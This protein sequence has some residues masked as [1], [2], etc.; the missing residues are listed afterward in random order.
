[1][2]SASFIYFTFFTFTNIFSNLYLHKAVEIYRNTKKL[3]NWAS[4]TRIF[5]ETTDGII[6]PCDIDD[7]LNSLTD[8]VDTEKE[9]EFNEKVFGQAKSLKF[10]QLDAT[11]DNLYDLRDD[12]EFKRSIKKN[13]QNT[14]EIKLNE[15]RKHIINQDNDLRD[16]VGQVMEDM[17][18][19]NNVNDG[20]ETAFGVGDGMN[21]AKFNEKYAN[22]M[23]REEAGLEYD[24]DI[25]L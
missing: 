15:H 18:D 12:F 25:L 1:M 3:P 20:N 2:V 4:T 13:P 7:I 9:R 17:K 19:G 14:A 11:S 24:N 5:L 22:Y 21:E 6:K 8:V 16:F 10:L 23:P